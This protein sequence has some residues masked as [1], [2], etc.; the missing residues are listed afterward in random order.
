MSPYCPKKIF[1]ETYHDFLYTLNR[2][3]HEI[4]ATFIEVH[5]KNMSLMFT[6]KYF[7]L[8]NE[9]NASD[10]ELLHE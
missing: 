3:M 7:F 5:D 10:K 2:K 8:K 4:L 9:T 1:K 6:C